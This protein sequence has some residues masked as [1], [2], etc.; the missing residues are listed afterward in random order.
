VEDHEGDTYRAV[1]TV[2]FKERIYV[3]HCFQK[4]SK[5]GDKTPQHDKQLIEDRLKM[6]IQIEAEQQK[7]R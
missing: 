6:A 5:K 7:G 2:K 3:L 1:Y 4:K